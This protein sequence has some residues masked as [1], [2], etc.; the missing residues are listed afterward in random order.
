MQVIRAIVSQGQILFCHFNDLEKAL[1]AV[2]IN[3]F[4]MSLVPTQLSR[5]FARDA[6]PP[7]IN[8]F[9][10]IFLGGGPTDNHLLA[11]ARDHALPIFLSYGMTETAGMVCAQ[12]QEA[13]YQGIFLRGNLCPE[14][15]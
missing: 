11:K 8:Q 6:I 9:K 15:K 2:A 10:A 5:L 1:E 4:C 14:W 3:D 13:F 12:S 7:Q